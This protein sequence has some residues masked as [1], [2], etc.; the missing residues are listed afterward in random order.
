M[1]SDNRSFGGK[2]CL[3]VQGISLDSSLLQMKMHC[4][5]ANV[6]ILANIPTFVT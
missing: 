4:F 1:E 5:E 3:H 6:I 2:Y